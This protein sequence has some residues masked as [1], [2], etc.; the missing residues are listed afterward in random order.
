ME[1][2]SKKT[3]W[4]FCGLIIVLALVFG[5]FLFEQKEEELGALFLDKKPIVVEE[6]LVIPDTKNVSAVDARTINSARDILLVPKDEGERA[7]V[8]NAV[9]TLKGSYEKA[10]PVATLWAKDAKLVFVKSLGTVNLNGMSSQWQVVFGSKIKK[11]GYEVIFQGD[12]QVSE[13]EIDSKLYGYDLPKNWYEVGEAVKSLGTLPQFADATISGVNFSYNTDG[14][15]WVYGIATS[16]GVTS[17]PV[18]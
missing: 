17:M 3:L 6:N 12:K 2:R 8:S 7:I 11:K 10:L 16:K 18:R 4:A 13:K 14:K 5:C 15:I 9:L 1:Q